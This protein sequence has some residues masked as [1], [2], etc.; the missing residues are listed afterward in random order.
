MTRVPVDCLILGQQL[1]QHEHAA[2][3][4]QQATCQERRPETTISRI[5]T[6]IYEALEKGGGYKYVLLYRQDRVIFTNGA[7]LASLSGFTSKRILN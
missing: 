5:H 3:P 6:H 4:Q 7:K 2:E 1:Q